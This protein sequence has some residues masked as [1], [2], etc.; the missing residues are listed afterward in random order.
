MLS[1]KTK[2]KIEKYL[3]YMLQRLTSSNYE[4]LLQI[5]KKQSKREMTKDKKTSHSRKY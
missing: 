5:S 2:V 4:E 1:Q 3:Q